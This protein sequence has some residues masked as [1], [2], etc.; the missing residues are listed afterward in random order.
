LLDAFLLA[1][2]EAN[3]RPI[4]DY[5]PVWSHAQEAGIPQDFVALA[6]F[7]FCRRFRAG[8]VQEEKRQKDWRKTFRN[9]VE[10]GYLKLW[11]IG[12]DGQYFLTTQ[13]KQAEAIHKARE[14][15]E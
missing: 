10:K 6:W 3:E 5:A 1:C 12:T 8:G 4:R 2:K 7:E 14:Q 15:H 13:G 9:Y 11:A